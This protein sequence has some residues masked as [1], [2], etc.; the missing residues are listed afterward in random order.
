MPWPSRCAIVGGS[1]DPA[2]SKRFA[3]LIG[4][5]SPSRFQNKLR[6]LSPQ[7]SRPKQ[8]HQNNSPNNTPADPCNVR[9]SGLPL[10]NLLM[11]CHR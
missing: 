6:L 11:N 7:G 1:G 3:T 5:G 8:E 4:V 2:L 10:E 9:V